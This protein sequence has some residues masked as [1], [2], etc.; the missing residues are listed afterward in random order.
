MLRAMVVI[1][2]LR[3]LLQHLLLGV[4]ILGVLA[5]PVFATTCEVSEAAATLEDGVPSAHADDAGAKDACCPL[6]N[7]GGC[8]SHA[9]AAVMQ[10]A[11]MS[12]PRPAPMFVA[13]PDQGFKPAPPGVD[14]R[15]P[16]R[17]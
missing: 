17:A 4:L 3:K 7:C 6:P 15:T 1:T 13:M 12:A 11:A 10:F 14:L 5:Q 9:A 8:C 2:P 16:I